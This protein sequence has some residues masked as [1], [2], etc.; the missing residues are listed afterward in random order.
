MSKPD[1]VSS[2]IY[3]VMKAAWSKG[4]K[5]GIPGEKTG[6]SDDDGDYADYDDGCTCIAPHLHHEAG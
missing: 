2:S 4:A 6:V 1:Q 3:L 5:I